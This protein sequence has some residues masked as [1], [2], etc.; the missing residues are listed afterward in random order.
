MSQLYKVVNGFDAMSGAAFGGGGGGGGGGNGGPRRG[1]RR[2]G[3]QNALVKQAADRKAAQQKR[4]AN[5][6]RMAAIANSKGPTSKSCV[7]DALIGG[8]VGAVTTK[9]PTAAYA[10]AT[11]SYAICKTGITNII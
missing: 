6:Q 10:A 8:L 11:S 5:F 4:E 3:S 2:P 9:N 7:D 1:S